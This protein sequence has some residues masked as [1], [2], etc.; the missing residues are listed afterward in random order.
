[1]LRSAALF[2]SLV[3][4]GAVFH[5]SGLASALDQKWIDAAVR[6]QGLRGEALFVA[7]GAMFITFGLPRQVIA[8]LAGYAFGLALGSALALLAAVLGC[9]AAFA[10]ARL[11]GR[12]L[13]ATRFPARVRRIDDFL[14]E[15]PLTMTLLIRFLPIGSN[16]ITNL[17]AGVSRVPPTPFIA[18]SALGYV[19][20]T[21]VFALIGS[22]VAVDL[23][24]RVGLGAIL[25]AASGALGVYLYRRHHGTK[26]LG[27]DIE[28]DLDTRASVTGGA[29]DPGA[30][31]PAGGR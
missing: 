4:I 31:P 3:A 28:R 16:L 27:D 14:A 15:N 5:F 2:L 25:F 10:Y 30:P 8:F 18:G 7:A 1:V 12:D 22:G 24:F 6:G 13:V 9:I 23:V 20:Q 11:L 21:V 17:A 29:R 19:P 26:T